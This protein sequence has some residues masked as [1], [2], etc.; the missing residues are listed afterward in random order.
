[1]ITKNR[2]MVIKILFWISTVAILT[3]QIHAEYYSPGNYRF[4][5]DKHELFSSDFLGSKLTVYSDVYPL[6]T[7]K[8]IVFRLTITPMPDENQIQQTNIYLNIISAGRG[9]LESRYE[10]IKNENETY[11]LEHTFWDQGN[12][13]FEVQ[14][15]YTDSSNVS[16]SSTFSFTQEVKGSQQQNAKEDNKN[17]MGMGSTMLIIMGVMMLVVMAAVGIGM[18]R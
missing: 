16:K 6:E 10:F 12:Y 3:N 9:L 1:M 8:K 4:P 5:V 13:K 17:G 2:H 15:N 14:I 11:F 7:K 18:H